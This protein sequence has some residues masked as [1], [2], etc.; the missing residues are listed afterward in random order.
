VKTTDTIIQKPR[1][2]SKVG[3]AQ[4]LSCQLCVVFGGWPSLSA[5]S[6]KSQAGDDREIPAEIPPEILT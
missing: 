4:P 3:L 6:E 5:V 2:K 1:R